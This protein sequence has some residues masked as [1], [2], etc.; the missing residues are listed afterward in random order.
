MSKLLIQAVLAVALETN[1]VSREDLKSRIEN[2]INKLFGDGAITGDTEAEVDTWYLR[3][4]ETNLTADPD[5][6]VEKLAWLKLLDEEAQQL[7]T[8]LKISKSE[9]V[10]FQGDTPEGLVVVEADGYG[11]ATVMEV[12]GNYPIDFIRKRDQVC[13]TEEEA[14]ALAEKW[15]DGDDEDEG[16]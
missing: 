4:R 15:L 13:A 14:E 6:V 9:E 7:R 16:E 8:E 1:G 3:I 12:E 11:G 10:I 5:G 2:D